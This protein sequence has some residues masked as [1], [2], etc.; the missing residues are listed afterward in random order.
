MDGME[1]EGFFSPMQRGEK[2]EGDYV[3]KAEGLNKF[4]TEILDF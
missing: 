4:G 1:K 3:P 2:R